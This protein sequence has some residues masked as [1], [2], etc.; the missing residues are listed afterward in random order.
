MNW[1]FAEANI[2][3]NS[4]G[5]WTDSVRRTNLPVEALGVGPLGEATQGS[6]DRVPFRGVLLST[7]PP[8]YDNIGYSDLS[9]FLCVATPRTPQHPPRVA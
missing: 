8:Y 3:G 1:D 9:D 5:N 2:F 4:T 7:D 6:A